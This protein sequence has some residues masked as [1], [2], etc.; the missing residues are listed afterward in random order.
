M[1]LS[2]PL[3]SPP[4][5]TVVTPFL[6]TPLHG[7][8]AAPSLTSNAN[9]GNTVPCHPAAWASRCPFPRLQRANGGKTAPCHPIA[10]H[11][12]HCPFPRLQPRELHHSSTIA[13]ASNNHFS[14][15]ESQCLSVLQ[16]FIVY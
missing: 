11:C 3:P 10:P 1:G 14:Y 6:A 8:L 15:C 7:P 4:M 16:C 2:L 9:G 13:N 5:Q 12:S